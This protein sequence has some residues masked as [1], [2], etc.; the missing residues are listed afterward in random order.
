MYGIIGM[1]DAGKST[2]VRCIN[3]LRSGPFSILMIMVIT[4]TR[5]IVGT[6]V[7]T[8]ASIILLVLAAFPFIARLAVK[9]DDRLKNQAK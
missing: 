7:G 3:L 9:S 5:L 1:S 6:S 2:L 4:L 8:T